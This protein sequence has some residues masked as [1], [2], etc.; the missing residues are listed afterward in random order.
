MYNAV[1]HDDAQADGAPFM[2]FDFVD[3]APAYVVVVGCRI[4]DIASK[5]GNCLQ[6]IGP[7]DDPDEPPVAND[8][9]A[10]DVVLLHER[11]EC[12][13]RSIFAD[14]YRR[15]RHD[16]GHLAT[17]LADIVFGRAGIAEKEGQR[18]AALAGRADLAPAQE[19]TLRYN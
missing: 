6:Q 18:P 14:G 5:T 2:L 11:H 8:R 9:K 4:W 12:R 16:F 1:A 10:L 13:Q 15:R 17:V 19:I 7:R 3:D